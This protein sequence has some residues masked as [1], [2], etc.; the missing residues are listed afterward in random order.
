MSDKIVATTRDFL[1][2]ITIALLIPSLGYY[3]SLIFVPNY[4]MY[5]SQEYSDINKI[6]KK[7]TK[8]KR[9]KNTLEDLQMVLLKSEEIKDHSRINNLKDEIGL[10]KEKIK[11]LKNLYEEKNKDFN[12]KYGDINNRSA[13]ILFYLSQLIGVLSI[14]AGIFIG[15]SAIKS[16]LVV[17]GLLA[18]I[19]GNLSY[20]QRLS[21][22][23][24]LVQILVLL[25][26]V[27]FITYRLYK[28]D[29]SKTKGSRG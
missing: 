22:I 16:G 8:L 29:E 11:N 13:K 27:I 21:E 28:D 4:N 9:N 5:L 7:I 18:V 10:V 15:I 19:L 23:S 25:A 20:W 17:G 3:L 26:F 1:L 2:N 14:L 12:K 6:S 24:K